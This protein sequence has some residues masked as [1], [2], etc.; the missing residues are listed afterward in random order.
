M[1]YLDLYGPPPEKGERG[2]T[3]EELDLMITKLAKEQANK[4][5]KP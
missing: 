5:E 4:L 1:N 2:A 3:P